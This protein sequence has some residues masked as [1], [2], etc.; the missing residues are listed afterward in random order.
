M[1]SN[2]ARSVGYDSQGGG[3]GGFRNWEMKPQV[4]KTENNLINLLK[5]EIWW[6]WE[7]WAQTEIGHFYFNINFT[8]RLLETEESKFT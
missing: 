7:K 5:F 2:F 1:S 3:A 6:F 4:N 8:L